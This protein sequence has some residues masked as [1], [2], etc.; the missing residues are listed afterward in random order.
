M[1]SHN[2]QTS[3]GFFAEMIRKIFPQLEGQLTRDLALA[4]LFGK[5]SFDDPLAIVQF[6]IAQSARRMIAYTEAITALH[7]KLQQS[8]IVAE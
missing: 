5:V 2:P 3:Y 4:I 6:L 8:P 1:N 7:S